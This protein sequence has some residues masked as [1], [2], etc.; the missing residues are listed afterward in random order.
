EETVEV[1]VDYDPG[2]VGPED[3]VEI[4]DGAGYEAVVGAGAGSY[5]PEVD[6]SDS[7][8]VEWLSREGEDVEIAASYVPGKVTVFD[9]YADWCGPCKEIDR[10]MHA[11][12][13]SSSD[14]A[15]RKINVVDWE[16][17]V[18]KHYL[19]RVSGLPYVVVYD[20]RGKQV[21]A[22]EGLDLERLRKA[23]EKGRRR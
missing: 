17:P 21:A 16:T 14:V 19:K 12:L 7:H 3:L 23:I 13:E 18:A 1:R 5:T 4:I 10:E 2:A 22:I 15:L 9:F 6:F 20:L 8:D 11:I